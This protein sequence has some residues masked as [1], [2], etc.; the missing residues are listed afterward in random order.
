MAALIG[1]LTSAAPVERPTA[2]EAAERLRWIRG[3]PARRLR[4][5]AIAGLVLAIIAGAAKYTIDLARERTIAVAARDEA[6]RRRTQAEN[7]IGF[8]LGD[9][10]KKLEPVGRLD[11]L[12][13]VGAKAMDYF[14][15]VPASALS[16]AELLRRSTALYQIGEVRIAQGNL[17][18]AARPLEES[19]AL[20]KT[21]V[22]RNPRDGERLF[23]LA[24]S[25]YWVGFVHWRRSKL[26][27]AQQQFQAY[28]DVAQTLTA[29]IRRGRTG[30]A[31]SH[32]PTATSA[33]SSRHAAISA[34]RSR[35]S[36]I[37]SR[38][39]RLCWRARPA[40]RSCPGPSPP[41]TMPSRS[42]CGPAGSWRRRSMNF[43]PSWRFRSGSPPPTRETSPSSR[44]VGVSHSYIG[45]LL[46][47]RG[48]AAEAR[49]RFDTAI[50]TCE[51][52]VARD[53]DNRT[54]QRDLAKNQFK[55]GLSLLQDRPARALPP[56]ERSVATLRVLSDAD[57]TNAGWQRDLAEARART[58]GR[59]C[60]DRQP[61][62]RGRRR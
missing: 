53:P 17:E 61:R 46:A 48:Q 8:M 33:P 27:A 18:A 24:Q 1:R 42:S 3:K 6:D 19:L 34:A 7:L 47:A 49:E 25:H 44:R 35:G 40:T 4:T 16:D 22:A 55:L 21:L 51:A 26:D 54:W 37:A 32:T 20:A 57:P 39:R 56:L 10:R 23:G 29:L 13:G 11:V 2:L 30:S 50:A 52:L 9:L 60:G 28:L 45:D 41:R 14:A 15:A 62:R 12:D 58:W 59:A 5:L 36:G 31:R 43:A 38:S